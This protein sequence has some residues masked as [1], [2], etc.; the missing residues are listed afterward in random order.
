MEPN[1]SVEGH[2]KMNFDKC[3]RGCLTAV[4][5]AAISALPDIAYAQHRHHHGGGI[6]TGAAV[7]LGLGAL[8]LGSAL[9]AGAYGYPYGYG[10]YQP[11]Y[12]SPAPAYYPRTCW[13][14]YY[15]RYYA[16]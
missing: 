15:G 11:Y 6:S 9:S 8:A 3:T 1:P 12:Y 4:I 10:Y 7:G 13:D 2:L 16:C 14:P 5:I